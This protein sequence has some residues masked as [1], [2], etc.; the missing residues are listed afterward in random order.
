MATIGFAG[1]THLG[2]VSG[3]SGSERGF[4]VVCYDAD[5]ARI[6]AI[7]E[8][9]L[10]VSEPRL[11]D[12]ARANNARL[13]FTDALADLAACDVVYVAP[14]VP[15]DDHGNSDLGPINA[16]LEAVFG[17]TKPAATIVVLSQVPPGFTRGKQ[18]TGRTLYYQVE[19]LVFGR[20]MQRALEPERYIV[21]AA[22]PSH[23]LP[24]AYRAFLEAH[25]CPILPMRYESAE[26]AK[27]SINMFL[28]ASVTT[29]NTLAEVCEKIGADWAEIVP[30][31]RLD[32]R[33]GQ[34]AYLNAGL[35]ISGGNLER[36]LGTILELSK[37]HGSDA[38]LVRAFLGSSG[39]RKG[40]PLRTLHKTVLSRA[41]S[42][43]IAVLGLSYKEDTH[44]TKNSPAIAL[45]QAL[46]PWPIRVYDPV[47]KADAVLHP[48]SVFA[49]SAVD[50]ANGADALAI[51]TPWAEFRNLPCNELARAMRG[52][53]VVDPYR[54]L[55]SEAA[56][57]AGLDVHCLGVT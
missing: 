50:A 1:M 46:K 53:I 42:P 20:A 10:P 52:R 9:R 43:T 56:K 4:N 8:G 6:A 47:V 35:G 37:E 26:L 40:W 18:R 31:L 29:A 45:I 38:E 49:A 12:L 11:D 23:P 28:V 34:H 13:K 48:K 32:K 19:T 27:I 39:H 2:L 7:R 54:L 5:C 55:D 3:I 44:S 57:S 51:M 30:A 21:G 17:V 25:A 33:I 22:D 14:D 41:A 16:L 36:D 15:T 24:A